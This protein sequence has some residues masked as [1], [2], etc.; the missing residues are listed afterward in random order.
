MSHSKPSISVVVDPANPGQFFACCGLLELADRRWGKAEGWFAEGRFHILSDGTTA[1]ILESLV[2]AGAEEVTK[3][4][5][6]LEVKPLIA[7][8]RLS[9]DGTRPFRLTLDAWMTTKID[10]GKI[11]TAANPPWNFWS[12]Q[13]TSLRIWRDL[14]G[15]FEESNRVHRCRRLG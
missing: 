13:Q 11:V 7:P 8:V 12:G 2:N 5:N 1:E 9:F 6:G 15:A 3:L 10:K 14:R 4:D